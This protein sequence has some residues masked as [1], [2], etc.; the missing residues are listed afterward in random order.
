[1]PTYRQQ[2]EATVDGLIR[3]GRIG[4]GM[5]DQYIQMLAADDK[6]AEY[7]ASTLSKGE[8]YTRKTQELAAQRRQ[9]E[10]EL[11]D[12]RSG[13]ER[14]RQNLQQWQTQAMG[15]LQRLQ[16]LEGSQAV[17]A[18]KVAAYEQALRDY[19]LLDQVQVPTVPTS[20][21]PMAPAQPWGQPPAS[22][23]AQPA[24]SQFIGRDEAASV[25]REM[26]QMQEKGLL[27]AQRHQ[28]LFGQPLM[29]PIVSESLAAGQDVEAYWRAKFN[30]GAREAE[31]AAKTREAEI[32]A[33]KQQAREEVMRELAN[34]PSRVVAGGAFGPMEKGLILQ[35][36]SLDRAE[37]EKQAALGTDGKRPAPERMS[38]L[39][40]S[41]A[42]ITEATQFFNQHFNPDG[43]PRA[44]APPT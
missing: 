14:E 7:F 30:V 15:E 2:I 38:D 4:Q 16:G 26:M 5:R 18:A 12:M 31:V 3:E 29:D 9:Q 35:Q 44:G 42:R 37:L 21:A 10:Q 27:L 36:Y 39:A 19:Q 20:A 25:L 23:P 33:I 43:T 24:Q 11:A 6:T 13:I 41:R 32:A 8:D 28:Q 17:L 22:R 40:L 1:M 34:D